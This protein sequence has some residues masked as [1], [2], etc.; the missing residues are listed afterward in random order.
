MPTFQICDVARG[1]PFESLDPEP[2]IR[3]LLLKPVEAFACDARR[4]VSCDTNTPWPR[5]PRTRSTCTTR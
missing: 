4:L 5:R 3:S 1:K 2:A